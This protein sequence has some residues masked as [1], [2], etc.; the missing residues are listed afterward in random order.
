MAADALCLSALYDYF[1]KH[2]ARGTAFAMS[3]VG[4]GVMVIPLLTQVF[5]DIYGWRGSMLL[6]GGL[7]LHI[8][9]CGSLLRP[10]VR[11][12]QM[13]LES[14]LRS[15]DEGKPKDAVAI[16]DAIGFPLFKSMNFISILILA[17]GG[18]YLITGWTVYLVPH[19][20]DLGYQPYEATL[21]ATA[22][23]LGYILG[24]FGFPFLTRTFSSETILYMATLLNCL[25]MLLDPL[26]GFLHSYTG[27]IVS[28]STFGAGRAIFFA[29]FYVIIK[30]TI[31]D[32]KQTIVVM[33]LHFWE[34][35]GSLAS[36]FLS[37]K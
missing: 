3:G 17:A 18:G 7:N 29:I 15:A 2:Y 8:V 33:W 21:L 1:D 22:G 16:F 25:S 37:G 6:I 35:C 36:G 19:A 28:S 31:D 30:E 13:E 34:N 14:V 12:A 4:F 11:K 27:M 10:T 32:D 9:L 20:L 26:S 5:M 24:S 23:G